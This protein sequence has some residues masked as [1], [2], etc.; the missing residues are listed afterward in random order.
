MKNLTQVQIGDVRY[1]SPVFVASTPASDSNEKVFQALE[2]G[3]GAVI[4]K[5]EI[6]IKKNINRKGFSFAILSPDKKTW[7]NTGSTA[8]EVDKGD[9][10]LIDLLNEVYNTGR[11]EM[12]IIPS[13]A[14]KEM[15]DSENIDYDGLIPTIEPVAQFSSD[16]SIPINIE[17]NF[18]YMIRV[19][20]R[21]LCPPHLAKIADE[22]FSLSPNGIT[23]IIIRNVIQ[24]TTFFDKV[25]KRYKSSIGI[26]VK[27][28]F[29]T[30]I[31]DIC[32]QTYEGNPIIKAFSIVNTI[33]SPG[34]LQWGMRDRT[35]LF[36]ISG[37]ALTEISRYST[38]QLYRMINLPI[39]CTGGV[40]MELQDSDLNFVAAAEASWLLKE[41]QTLCEIDKQDQSNSYTDKIK[42]KAN[43]KFDS[44]QKLISW[45]NKME[46]IAEKE[47]DIDNRI[48]LIKKEFKAN[49]EEFD[50]NQVTT[51]TKFIKEY[52][53][54]ENLNKIYFR[55]ILALEDILDR[56]YVGSSAVQIGTAMLGG[57]GFA[58]LKRIC[59]LMQA[60]F[61]SE[62]FREL[63]FQDN[64]GALDAGD[65][66]LLVDRIVHNTNMKNYIGLYVEE[67]FSDKIEL[68][69]PTYE[70][71]K[72]LCTKCGTCIDIPYCN[73]AI[74]NKENSFEIDKTRCGSCGVCFQVC[75][76]K[77]IVKLN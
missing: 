62:V 33:K 65:N 9:N 48:K 14:T 68:S 21:A 20:E 74:L 73:G 27:F 64:M 46:T 19:L 8:H 37:S 75:E 72:A 1:K 52:R 29:R 34:K 67:R 66:R 77:A 10:Y 30:D 6:P 28:P 11:A 32:T 69:Q 42:R 70:I 56:I 35:K 44:M 15:I 71:D 47:S 23:K 31:G 5:T 7:F 13:V 12:P 50:G 58:G 18:R 25:N 2:A 63:V 41:F 51:I 26:I 22:Y 17:V 61:E 55:S 3:A 53:E 24:M 39:I 49:K 59:M 60:F 54:K 45:L 36:Q 76:H 16:K 4:L 38:F 57:S 40:A 43:A